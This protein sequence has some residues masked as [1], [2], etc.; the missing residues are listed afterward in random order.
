MANTFL[1]KDM[2]LLL[3]GLKKTC[4]IL[5]EIGCLVL[6]HNCQNFNIKKHIQLKSFRLNKLTAE[7]QTLLSITNVGGFCFSITFGLF[8]SV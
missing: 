3:I 6:E 5:S 4:S 7:K 2:K 8:S 1:R